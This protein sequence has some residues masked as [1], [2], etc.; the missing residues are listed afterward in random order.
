MSRPYCASINRLFTC[1][2]LRMRQTPL[3]VVMVVK[4]RYAIENAY[5]TFPNSCYLPKEF[6]VTFEIMKSI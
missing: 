1:G 2:V 3:Q 5:V 4:Q 6:L